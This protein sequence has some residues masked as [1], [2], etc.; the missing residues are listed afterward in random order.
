VYIHIHA[1][2]VYLSRLLYYFS[3][4]VSSCTSVVSGVSSCTSIVSSVSSS[5]VL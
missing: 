3:S 1:Y 2:I 4:G 5:I